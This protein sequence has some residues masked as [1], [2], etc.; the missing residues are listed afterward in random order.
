MKKGLI[1]KVINSR[2]TYFWGQYYVLLYVSY[3]NKNLAMYT[4][5]S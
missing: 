4:N 1:L 3:Q 5:L 2:F